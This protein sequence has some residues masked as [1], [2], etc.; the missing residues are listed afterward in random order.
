MDKN[1]LKKLEQKRQM[2]IESG[3]VNGLQNP[4]TIRLSKQL[5]QLMNQFEGQ[6]NKKENE[7]S[8][9]LLQ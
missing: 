1:L 7:Q 6:T 2:M 9:N 3:M 4:K 8:D 5:D